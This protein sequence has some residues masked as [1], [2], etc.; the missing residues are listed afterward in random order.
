LVSGPKFKDA[1]DCYA[2]IEV[3][4]L[5][6]RIEQHQGLV[7]LATNFHKNVDEAFLRRLPLRRFFLI[8]RC[9]FN[10]GDEPRGLLLERHHASKKFPQCVQFKPCESGNGI[11]WADCRAIVILALLTVAGWSICAIFRAAQ[12]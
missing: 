6:Q 7:V 4:Y 3:N 9:G 5:L 1:H 2:N 11:D 8:V 12:A 10:E